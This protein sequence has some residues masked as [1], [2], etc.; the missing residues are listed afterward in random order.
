MPEHFGLYL[1]Q[2]NVFFPMKPSPIFHIIIGLLLG[3]GNPTWLQA[4]TSVKQ[5]LETQDVRTKEGQQTNYLQLAATFLPKNPDSAAVWIDLAGKVQAD[6]TWTPAYIDGLIQLMRAYKKKSQ[7]AQ[8][9][10]YGRHIT[11]N[12]DRHLNVV[13]QAEAFRFQGYSLAVTGDVDSS[14]SI[15]SRFN[16]FLET[17][18][19]ADSSQWIDCTAQYFSG[20]GITNAISN[21]PNKALTCFLT[22]DS[23]LRLGGSEELR[24]HIKY[25][26]GTIFY[27]L[28]HFVKSN[29]YYKELE[30]AHEAGRPIADLLQMYDNMVLNYMNLEQFDTAKSYL[31]KNL[32][33]ARKI[34]DSI[35][36]GF[37][38]RH[39]G[40]IN[41]IEGNFKQALTCFKKSAEVYQSVQY[42]LGYYDV[43]SAYVQCCLESGIG[44]AE[45]LPIAEAMVTYYSKTELLYKKLMAYHYR[46]MV[47]HQLGRSKE[48]FGDYIIYDSLNNAYLKNSFSERT[49]ELETLHQTNLHKQK[50]KEQ[51]ELTEFIRVESESKSRLL[52]AVTGTALLLLLILI[53]LL[54]LYR[55]LMQSKALINAQKAN[56]E[57]REAEKSTLL[58]E[59]HHRV[60][61]NLQIV[62]SLLNLQG[63]A[64]NDKVA[65]GAFKS[66]QN[67]VEAM[68]MIHRYLYATDELTTLE[69][70]SYLTQLVRSIA[71]SYG[72]DN[73]S[74][75]LGFDI[76]SQPIDVDLA[77]PLGLIA[78]ELVSNAFKH[79][80]NDVTEPSLQIG[81]QLDKDLVL[82]VFDNGPGI[83]QEKK[84]EAN[85]S[86]G[87]ELVQSLSKQLK[88]DLIFKYQNGTCVQLTIPELVVTKKQEF[89]SKL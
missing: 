40:S 45:C 4:Q 64:V 74:I 49:A 25:C 31:A 67:R 26:L 28:G 38:Y 58:K 29:K 9:L 51:A 71:H 56:I 36:V 82:T 6:E 87:M 14:M 50:A 62:S 33:E 60:K 79:A 69:V 73:H 83:T 7:F 37:N 86:F 76:T 19:I 65:Q 68:A 24:F 39:L 42:T 78:N 59:L 89:N 18:E 80:F 27:E 43:Q 23:L 30:K 3:I 77:I 57:Q 16:T 46:A 81:L 70:K 48:G 41:Q 66:G 53:A 17:Q 75:T 10:K 1:P 47:L 55:R 35:T 11:Q 21:N 34:G 63:E 5:E 12:F 32:I 84:G 85:Y 13:G 22:G 15:Y 54:V 8:V 72:H 52:F 2:M 20:L 88:A 61:N 44:V